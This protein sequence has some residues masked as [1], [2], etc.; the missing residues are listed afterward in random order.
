MSDLL[1]ANMRRRPSGAPGSCRHAQ[2]HVCSLD[3]RGR[4]W[5]YECINCRIRW[6][7]P[8]TED[9]APLVTALRGGRPLLTVVK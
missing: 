7:M 8:V 9:D 4:V 2:Q 6:T 1:H 5:R 3:E